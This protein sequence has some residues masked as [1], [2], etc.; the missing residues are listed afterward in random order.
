MLTD[1][2]PRFEAPG[3]DPG[4]MVGHSEVKPYPNLIA[5]TEGS[6]PLPVS[7][8]IAQESKLILYET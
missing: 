6:A 5:Q 8:L 1:N 7:V 2:A 3:P 4:R